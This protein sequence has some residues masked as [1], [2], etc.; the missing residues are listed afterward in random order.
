MMLTTSPEESLRRLRKRNRVEEINVSLDY[1]EKLFK[2]TEHA[3]SL[4]K[5]KQVIHLEDREYHTNDSI[6][7][8]LAQQLIA[9]QEGR[10]QSVDH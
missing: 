1:L 2:E 3:L 7:Y 6:V 10:Q 5:G 9:I 4:I 8:G